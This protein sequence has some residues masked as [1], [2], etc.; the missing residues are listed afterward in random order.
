MRSSV[1][2]FRARG[3]STDRTRNAYFSLG[4][5]CRWLR[6]VRMK[7]AGE[8]IRST[9]K[10]APSRLEDCGNPESVLSRW[11]S[12]VITWPGMSSSTSLSTFDSLCKFFLFLRHYYFIELSKRHRVRRSLTV[13][14]N[15][16]WIILDTHHTRHSVFSV[17]V[18]YCSFLFGMPRLL[19]PILSSICSDR[20]F[21][22]G[23]RSLPSEFHFH[24][25]EIIAWSA[26]A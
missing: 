14:A 3:M 6:C 26:R 12:A 23:K 4:V 10:A 18:H 25:A 11:P 24:F 13:D 7:V 2:R 17:Y 15:V 19:L 1:K 21:G 8:C 22:R 16:H 20:H 9:R 5:R